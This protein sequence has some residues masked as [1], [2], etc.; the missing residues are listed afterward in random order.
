MP[1]INKGKL[2][3]DAIKV[4]VAFGKHAA[5]LVIGDEALGSAVDVVIDIL[6]ED[7]REKAKVWLNKPE[8]KE[9]I[10][11]VLQETE[12]CMRKSPGLPA[13]VRTKLHEAG[14]KD[15]FFF[16]KEYVVE[17]MFKPAS[18]S[19]E[20]Q[21]I[22]VIQS[23]LKAEDDE[24]R[25]KQRQLEKV[26]QIFI[27]CLRKAIVSHMKGDWQEDIIN[28]TILKID[29][30]TTNT[31]EVV[32][33]MAK[34]TLPGIQKSI[35][36]LTVNQSTPEKII[37]Q[38]PAAWRDFTGREKELNDLRERRQTKQII[39][40]HGAPGVGK[41]ALALDYAHQI[42]DDYPDGQIYL[43]LR[44]VGDTKSVPGTPSYDPAPLTTAQILTHILFELG[45]STE[46]ITDHEDQLLTLYRQELNGKRLLILLDNASNG[47]QIE[48]AVQITPH[49]FFLVTSRQEDFPNFKP[50]Y[51]L[52]KMIPE[53]AIQ[54]LQ[55]LCPTRFREMEAS[56]L[57]E[58][59][60][61]LP[62]ALRLAG[63]TL[64]QK[65]YLSGK[66]YLQRLENQTET[67]P[68]I[69]AAIQVSLKLLPTTPI[70]YLKQWSELAVFAGEFHSYIAEY[71]C[72]PERYLSEDEELPSDYEETLFTLKNYG[73]LEWDPLTKLYDY[74]DALRDYARSLWT[75]GQEKE[76]RIQHATVFKG[77]LSYFDDLFT[78]SEG[79]ENQ[80]YQQ[81]Q[82]ALNF[83]TQEENEIIQARDWL[84]ECVN[85]GEKDT[86]VLNLC[87]QFYDA[88][89]YLLKLRMPAQDRILWLKAAA[90][91]CQQI[92][93][94]RGEGTTLG[95][96]GL[97]YF[98]LGE[99]HKAIEYHQEALVI[100]QEI[101]DRRGEGNHLGNLGNAYFTL[102]EIHKAIEYHQEALV[103][104]KEIGDRQGE[105]AD[106]SSL[107]LAYAD[108][109]EVQK[110]IEYHQQALAISREIGDKRGEGIH[111]GNLGNA[112]FVL[113]EVQK[114]IEYHQEAL[115]I[116]QEIGDKR[117]EGNHLGNL[118]NAF[119]NLGEVQKAIEYYQQA[120]AIAQ[121]TGDRQ[122]EGNHSFNLAITIYETDKT[123]AHQLVCR[124]YHIWTK[125]GVPDREK[126]L[127][128]MQE[129]GI[130]PENCV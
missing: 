43:N 71:I 75:E 102:G 91:A 93:D 121:K 124:A 80:R 3:A 79:D 96:L 99:I 53:D 108:L 114:A 50:L 94:R 109:G 72:S 8:L 63:N 36:Q 15:G 55:K 92:G 44:G 129:W 118:G 9:K 24:Q 20:A 37:P 16:S 126:A 22:K 23:A 14:Q 5:G 54:F 100:A 45:I 62:L 65:Q 82:R 128:L 19:D 113:G 29:D 70:N 86:T 67:L 27:K 57:A 42:K 49:N 33:D 107:G 101:G 21:L 11:L 28:Q 26:S 76:L 116:A 68:L 90:L 18:T 98:T 84:V 1:K 106:L 59:L 52:H 119:F 51:H 2:A 7:L 25:L 74:H 48:K 88:G 31:N 127:A 104:S 105:E 58:K 112:Y 120:L 130:S 73:L 40:I 97:A 35:D 81:R 123:Q 117:G 103:I 78:S 125:M 41:T 47:A 87:S 83:Y 12:T 85:M 10:A 111:L 30:T 17:A 122:G 89:V 32:T 69:E 39:I 46:G 60:G 61:F 34:V 64:N 38:M 110:A 95:N 66:D 13:Y 4:F 56:T 77:L 6:G 115:V